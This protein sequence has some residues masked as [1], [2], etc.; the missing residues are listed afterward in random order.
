MKQPELAKPSQGKWSTKQLSVKQ[1]EGAQTLVKRR[2]EPSCKTKD[3]EDSDGTITTKELGVSV[4][5]DDE[6][7]ESRV[8]EG[9]QELESA[10]LNVQLLESV[11][12]KELRL[13]RE[14]V[15]EIEME[16]NGLL[17]SRFARMKV[18]V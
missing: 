3:T 6:E 4:E 16:L 14:R 10:R 5:D 2:E 1:E 8:S 17:T 18:C 7:W 9:L 12:H 11:V 15:E 13:A